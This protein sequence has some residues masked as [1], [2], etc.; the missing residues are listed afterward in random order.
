MTS[1][2]MQVEVPKPDLTYLN[3]LVAAL[4]RAPARLN[5]MPGTVVPRPNFIPGSPGAM[6]STLLPE[7]TQ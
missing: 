3:S 7:G 6:P 2:P 1:Q 4:R 5:P